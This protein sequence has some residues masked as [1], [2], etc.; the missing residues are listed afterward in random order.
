M[1]TDGNISATI[2][3]DTNSKEEEKNNNTNLYIKVP[4]N[5]TKIITWLVLKRLTGCHFTTRGRH[6]QQSLGQLSESSA[7]LFL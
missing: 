5:L 3:S 6:V 1:Y 2:H 4:D 7:K